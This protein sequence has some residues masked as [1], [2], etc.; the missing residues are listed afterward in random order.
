MTTAY[1]PFGVPG[2][3]RAP[4]DP[5][6]SLPDHPSGEWATAH[7]P[8]PRFGHPRPAVHATEPYLP[9]SSG[10]ASYPVVAD[11]ATEPA[12]LNGRGRSR[13]ATLALVLVLLVVAGWQ[14]WRLDR[15][16]R[17]LGTS[18]EQLTVALQQQGRL[19]ERADRLEQQ[20]AGVFDPEAISS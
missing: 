13:L 14:A 18:A 2:P 8:V 15:V 10:A 3:R 9:S 7:R 6:L 5:L 16:D 4:Q 19:T 1:D 20:L 17:R 11:P 12:V